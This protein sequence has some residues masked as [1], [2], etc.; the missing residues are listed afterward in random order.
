MII[1][2]QTVPGSANPMCYNS[3]VSVMTY[4]L[5]HSV[6][7]CICGTHTTCLSTGW[8]VMT[9]RQLFKCWI[10]S[11]FEVLRWS[12]SISEYTWDCVECT[13]WIMLRYQQRPWI[14]YFGLFHATNLRWLCALYNRT[15]YLNAPLLPLNAWVA[16]SNNWYKYADRFVSLESYTLFIGTHAGT[17]VKSIKILGCQVYTTHLVTVYPYCIL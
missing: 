5:F 14:E 7:H 8:H 2:Q 9:L 3:G 12:P 13:T 17:N 15:E 11:C 6:R 1:E 4:T 16:K 10:V